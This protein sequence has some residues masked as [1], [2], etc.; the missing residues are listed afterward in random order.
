MD[1]DSSID[2]QHKRSILE[3]KEGI[4]RGQLQEYLVQGGV[5]QGGQR[6]FQGLVGICDSF[7]ESKMRSLCTRLNTPVVEDFTGMT[8][9]CCMAYTAPHLQ[10]CAPQVW[11]CEL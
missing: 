7:R 11:Y 9:M 3:G 8:I 5:R 1:I 4:R 2:V 10:D 6:G